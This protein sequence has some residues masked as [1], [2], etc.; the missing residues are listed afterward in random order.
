MNG[1]YVANYTSIYEDRGSLWW[2]GNYVHYIS[3]N[4]CILNTYTDDKFMALISTYCDDAFIVLINAYSGDKFIVLINTYSDD[5]FI[6]IIYTYF[7]DH[8]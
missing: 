1:V 7:G 8:S 5:K 2:I 4:L 6:V 3:Q